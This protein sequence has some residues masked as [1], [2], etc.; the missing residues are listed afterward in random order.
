[1]T[2]DNTL[3]AGFLESFHS[4]YGNKAMFMIAVVS[5]LYLIITTRRERRRLVFPML[6]I[7]VAVLNPVFYRLT[8]EHG[9]YWYWR[10]LWM[11]SETI[12]SALAITRLIKA[13]EGVYLKPVF[14][15]AFCVLIIMCGSYAF[16]PSAFSK[17]RS[18]EKLRIGTADICDMILEV[19]KTPHVVMCYIHASDARQYNGDIT[20]YF[21]RY[22]FEVNAP[23]NTHEGKMCWELEQTSPDYDYVFSTAA[24][25]GFNFIVSYGNR[26]VAPG[27]AESYGYRNIG[28]TA[29]VDIWYNQTVIEAG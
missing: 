26:P 24:L 25:D 4:Y 9:I 1:M 11:F 29:G 19:D 28:G 27:L 3:I 22:S 12:I 23:Y 6:F 21:D 7:L 17:A 16:R 13:V 10:F 2:A 15:T 8:T 20:L 14:F 5:C 18:L